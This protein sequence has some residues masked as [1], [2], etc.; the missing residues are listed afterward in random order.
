MFYIRA[1]GNTHI[2]MGH[3]MRCLSIADAAY[4]LDKENKAVF[5][6]ADM[7]CQKMIHDRGYEVKVLNTDYMDMESEIAI[8][9]TF[10]KKTDVILVDSYQVTNNYYLELRNISRVACLEDMGNSYPVNLLVNYNIYGPNLKNRYSNSGVDDAS[11]VGPD[12]YIL[13]LDYMPLRKEFSMKHGYEIKEDVASVMITTGGS[14]PYFA[15]DDFLQAILGDMDLKSENIVYHVVS[16][17]FN[18]F[19]DSLKEKYGSIQNVV[20]HENVKDMKGLIL[21]SDV[22]I[23][24]T[25]S[26]IYEVSA[27]GVPM[28]CFYFAENQ[29]QGAEEIEK[30]T[31]IVN[32]GCLADNKENVVENIVYALKKCIYSKAYRDKIHMQEMKL[33]DG[34]GAGRLANEILSLIKGVI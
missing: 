3:V 1:D 8:L 13:G 28:I 30:L 9:K 2:G 32:A 31:D 22:V 24:A 34:K 27:L 15:T 20:I 19:A 17:P 25:G 26:T 23:T 6:V 16:G 33:V 14:D 29:R 18:A 10:I 4:E 5:I 21:E 12:R 7:D 11:S